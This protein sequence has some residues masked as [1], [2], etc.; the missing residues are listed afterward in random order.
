MIKPISLKKDRIDIEKKAK[1]IE[2]QG[3]KAGKLGDNEEETEEIEKTEQDD[4]IGSKGKIEN[5]EEREETEWRE[6]KEK[7]EYKEDREAKG[8][9]AK[10]EILKI[11]WRLMKIKKKKILNQEEWIVFKKVH[12]RKNHP[13]NHQK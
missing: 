8:F 1:D 7:R 10:T 3:N 13:K 12:N 5:K 6:E 9:N 4:Q 2:N 11:D